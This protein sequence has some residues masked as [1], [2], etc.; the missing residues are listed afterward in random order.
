MFIFL[1]CSISFDL[2]IEKVWHGDLHSRSYS[3]LS[4]TYHASSHTAIAVL[5]FTVLPLISF[6]GAAF[7]YVKHNERKSHLLGDDSRR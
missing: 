5:F 7:S 3:I 2:W 4:F 1:Q 6:G